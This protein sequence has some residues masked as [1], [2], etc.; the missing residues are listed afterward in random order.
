MTQEDEDIHSSARE[1]VN[2]LGHEALPYVQSRIAK[3]SE[4]G[5]GSELDQT[6]NAR[7]KSYHCGGAK[8]YH[9]AR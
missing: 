8:G 3:L 5:M 9:F 1:L 7:V 2:R 4:R 6:V